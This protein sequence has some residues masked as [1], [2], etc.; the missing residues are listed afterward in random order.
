MYLYEN[1]FSREH[2]FA[3][4]ARAGKFLV[5]ASTPRCGSHM[6]GHALHQI[7]CFGF[8]LEYANPVNLPEWEKQLQRQGF[9]EVLDELMRRRTSSNGVFAIKIHYEHIATFGGFPALMRHFPNAFYLLL[10]RRDALRQAVSLSRAK[11]TGVWIAGQQASTHPPQYSYQDINQS[12]KRVLMDT[13]SWRYLLASHGCRHLEMSFEQ[14]SADLDGTA[15]L[16]AGKLGIEAPSR[17]ARPVTHRQGDELNQQWYER[18][19]QQHRASSDS[20]TRQD[21]LLDK[22]FRRMRGG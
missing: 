7:G 13:A 3:T 2:D 15:A 9:P 20:L 11:Q 1:Q 22:V 14:A 12:L 17:T 8:P 10:T 16:L 18:F 19:L 6:L 21:G 4:D 5:I